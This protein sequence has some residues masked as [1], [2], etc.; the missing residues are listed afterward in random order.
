MGGGSR[1]LRLRERG[2]DERPPRRLGDAG[3]LLAQPHRRPR[4]GLGGRLRRVVG[5]RRP[6]GYHRRA[7][8][9]CGGLLLSDIV[10]LEAH[11]NLRDEWPGDHHLLRPL[12]PRGHRALP[13]QETC[14]ALGRR[15]VPRGWCIGGVRCRMGHH[16]LGAQ[17]QGLPRPHPGG[18]RVARLLGPDLEPRERGCR[19]L[20][21]V[22]VQP[23]A[24]RGDVAHRPHRHHGLGAWLLRGGRGGAIQLL[25]QARKSRCRQGP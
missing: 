20:R 13:A 2:D 11:R 3:P 16:F 6:R 10:N 19:A 15:I 4:G 23:R 5:F 22:Q 25:E 21:R 18:R 7:C 24:P 17:G 14:Q 8:R 12:H 1:G 9:R